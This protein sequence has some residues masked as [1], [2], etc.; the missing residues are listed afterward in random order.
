MR[1]A[2]SRLPRSSTLPGRPVPPARYAATSGSLSDDRSRHPAP[3]QHG[4]GGR[5]PGEEQRGPCALVSH[6]AQR[7][8]QETRGGVRART[9][10]C[11]AG[12]ERAGRHR[13]EYLPPPMRKRSRRRSLPSPSQGSTSTATQSPRPPCAALPKQSRAPA[14]LW[15][16]VPWSAPSDGLEVPRLYAAGPGDALARVTALFKGSTVRVHELPGPSARLPRSSCPT[17]A[18]RKRAGRWPRSRTHSLLSMASRKSY[19][20]LRGA[21]EQLPRGDG[22][23]PE[24]RS[25]RVALGSRDGGGGPRS[26]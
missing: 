9:S 1:L 7:G 3:R 8:E 12:A 16:T 17:A 21:G 2:R 10:R 25:A 19:S 15:S 24:D 18:T 13:P 20:T 5:G 26:R 23:L 22:V 11:A 4:G 6:G 14:R